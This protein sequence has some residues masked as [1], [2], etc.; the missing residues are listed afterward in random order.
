MTD[1]KQAVTMSF[2]DINAFIR[3]YLSSTNLNDPKSEL[4]FATIDNFLSQNEDALLHMS[5]LA[6]SG[7][8]KSIKEEEPKAV[9][10]ITVR[11]TVY[12]INNSEVDC[13]TAYLIARYL[14]F[15]YTETLLVLSQIVSSTDTASLLFSMECV[16]H[17]RA[18]RLE[19]LSLLTSNESFPVFGSK[20]YKLF[21]HTKRIDICRD[22]QLLLENLITSM[23]ET[24]P[25]EE[26]DPSLSPNSI[27]RTDYV[28]VALLKNYSN[29][30]Y[31]ADLLKLLTNL[32]LNTSIPGDIVLHWF[33]ILSKLT[34]LIR[35][36][37][38]QLISNIP[39]RILT[40]LDALG[41]VVSLLML[42]F[43]TTICAID[44]DSPYFSDAKVFQEI[45]RQ[46]ESLSPPNSVLLYAWSFILYTKEY[47]IEVEN[48]GE[49]TVEIQEELGLAFSGGNVSLATLSTLFA[50]K[51]ES[52][53]VLDSFISL[54]E[55]LS[56]DTLF[57]IILSSFLTYQLHFTPITSKVSQAIKVVLSKTPTEFV[58][59]FLTSDIF[60]ER[61]RV[62]M[63]KLPLVNEA[64]VPLINI[65][66]ANI[67]FADFELKELNT[68]ATKTTLG[69]IDY[70]ILDVEQM[71]D[72]KDGEGL[73]GTQT[74]SEN[75]G[76]RMIVSSSAAAATTDLI[77]L[78]SQLLVRP[79]LE[80]HD[81]VRLPIPKSTRGRVLQITRSSELPS[82]QPKLLNGDMDKEN[83]SIS[84]VSNTTLS[85]STATNDKTKMMATSDTTSTTTTTTT[86]TGNILIFLYRYS[87][88]SLLGRGLANL[89]DLYIQ[90]GTKIEHTYIDILV[91]L[92]DLITA[93]VSPQTPK[94]TAT[95]IVESLSSSID[96]NDDDKNGIISRVFKL[97]ETAVGKRDYRLSCTCCSFTNALVSNF[98]PA[99]WS[100]LTYTERLDKYNK[101]S[102]AT[103]V[104]GNL[105]L[106][107]GDYNFTVTF[108][109]LVDSLVD[110]VLVPNSTVSA[111]TKADTI[112]NLI[113]HLLNVYQSYRFWQFNDIYQ[114]FEL[115]VLLTQLFMKVLHNVYVVDPQTPP[116]EK[117]SGALA[118]AASD[119][120]DEFLGLHALESGATA[121]LVRVLTSY[122][123][124]ELYS[125][126]NEAFDPCYVALVSSSYEFA[127]LLILMR[128]SQNLPSSALEQLIFQSA[129]TFVDIYCASR[130]LRRPVL[131]LLHA[132][133]SVPW[134][135]DNF[136][137]LLSYLG[138]EHSRAFFR[139]ISADLRNPLDNSE[140]TSDIYC[141]LSALMTSKQDGLSILFLTGDIASKNKILSSESN[142]GKTSSKTTVNTKEDKVLVK[143][144]QQGNGEKDKTGSRESSLTL[145][146][147][148]VVGL[149]K[150][151]DYAACSL[152][153][154]IAN[155]FNMWHYSHY[156]KDD[157]ELIDALIKIF[158]DLDISKLTYDTSM[159]N[160]ELLDLSYKYRLISRIVEIFALHLFTNE[161]TKSPVYKLLNEGGDKLFALM[162]LYFSIDNTALSLV[163]EVENKFFELGTGYKLSD[164]RLAPFV[165]K[166]TRH[167]IPFFDLPLMR[168]LLTST[169]GDDTV[170][171]ELK[172]LLDK[173]S[174]VTL[175]Q[176][177]Q[178]ATAKV[179]GALLTSFIRVSKYELDVRYIE[180]VS[181]F[182]QANI[183]VAN[184]GQKFCDI[185]QERIELCFYFLNSFR[186]TSK[187]IPQGK[188]TEL[189]T[190]LL[191]LLK[192]EPTQFLRSIATSEQA[193]IYRPILRSSLIVLDLV[194]NKKEFVELSSAPLLEFF[195]WTFSK[196]VHAILSDILTSISQSS[197]I[198]GKPLVINNLDE[199]IRDL[200]LLYSIFEHVS[201]LNPPDAFKAAIAS[202]LDETGTIKVLLNLYSTS[203]YANKDDELLLG[204]LTLSFI[205]ELCTVKQVSERLITGGLF[206]VLLESKV[207]VALQNGGV[208]PETDPRL[209]SMWSRGLLL[210]VMLLLSEF[211]TKIL[212]ECCLFISYFT[213]QIQTTVYSWSDSKLAISTALIRETSQYILLQRMLAALNYQHY[214]RSVRGSGNLDG[215]ATGESGEQSPLIVGLDTLEERR[216]LSRTLISLLTHPKYLNSRI[217]PCT[218][219][220]QQALED[221]KSRSKFFSLVNDEI[222]ELQ[223]SLAVQES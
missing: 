139:A 19:T 172:M 219:E 84:T 183:D 182:L 148:K 222:E 27:S 94:G 100:Y 21:V 163:G 51:A 64:L 132:L 50:Q 160:R 65:C 157:E 192:S 96:G 90:N 161:S 184:S 221:E 181:H 71:L 22:L 42:G 76:E 189:L 45:Q 31:L 112:K 5:L 178:T 195:Q 75:K 8:G 114:Q 133:V 124:K 196:G 158:K 193:Q 67:D 46:I 143:A 177:Y 145:L 135:G 209:Q 66:S 25:L 146:K 216:D 85:N 140:L 58:E 154:A 119:I 36:K 147:K 200:L 91:S 101:T 37:L 188:L 20:Y 6:D 185:C 122:I 83:R 38:P 3:S 26:L 166:H 134:N 110:E 98:A 1:A 179:W 137:F 47:Q 52:M 126:G 217:V 78:K 23:L 102:L 121:N 164:F 211:G 105:E 56:A 107:N 127:T 10:S 80:F 128:G 34:D 207:S 17:E 49:D 115:G 103:S 170:M 95:E 175:C 30:T 186:Q 41:T 106:P 117:F 44:V 82:F 113:R 138:E 40:H 24:G 165:N 141:F 194:A 155:A 11:G 199:K 205:S 57:S 99:V 136:P 111:K 218:L 33:T 28:N 48:G 63:A 70:D 108:T 223:K 9:K 215:K 131:G 204:Q 39:T 89:I 152:L 118:E 129:S 54:Y 150:M 59:R 72:T 201:Q 203:P 169:V 149:E 18:A 104:L 88:W 92:V 29:L 7:L 43:N 180:L 2:S 123:N 86:T 81:N 206:A 220:E 109:K 191:T 4:G 176:D 62:L 144:S 60:E 74:L 159:S 35:L 198:P 213:K 214:L 97:F 32:I 73:N 171:A 130:R 142:R 125:I 61:L 167:D 13:H 77:E 69:E 173:V 168:K 14:N 53:N 55:S 208:R 153:D 12:E 156:L 87:G 16:L 197:S 68:Y 174:L 120:A 190:K 162:K 151:A 210:I 116:R 93:V 79:P 15:N 212:P 187:K 202:S